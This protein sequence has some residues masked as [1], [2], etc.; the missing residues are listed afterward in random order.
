MDAILG[1][2]QPS[3]RDSETC[4]DDGKKVSTVDDFQHVDDANQDSAISDHTVPLDANSQREASSA[5]GVVND[6]SL[7]ASI[8]G[9][10]QPA[11]ID[12]STKSNEEEKKIKLDSEQKNKGNA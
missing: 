9:S 7:A 11:N 10:G 5:P 1:K 3:R 4:S 2:G 12:R 8:S 6:V